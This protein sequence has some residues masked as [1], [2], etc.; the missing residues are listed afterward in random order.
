[1]F[2]KAKIAEK[3]PLKINN[4]INQKHR[5]LVYTN[6]DK[7]FKSNVENRALSSLHWGSLE[8]TLPVP[9]TILTA[10]KYYIHNPPNF[11]NI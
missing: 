1:M 3:L 10:S 11:I 8:I 4:L 9:E 2:L 6:S 7:A 5:Y